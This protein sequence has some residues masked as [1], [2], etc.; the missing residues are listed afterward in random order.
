MP[1]VA[2]PEAEGL[3]PIALP[4]TAA[5]VSGGIRSVRTELAEDVA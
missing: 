1:Y 3:L 4:Q 2:L 5:E